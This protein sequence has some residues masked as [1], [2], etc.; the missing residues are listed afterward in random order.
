MYTKLVRYSDIH[1]SHNISKLVL[2]ITNNVE[3]LELMK[4]YKK[5]EYKIR[6]LKEEFV[7]I[8]HYEKVLKALQKNL[9]TKFTNKH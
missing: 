4:S 5:T 8:M 1:Q 2:L 6:E 3:T 7:V 9:T